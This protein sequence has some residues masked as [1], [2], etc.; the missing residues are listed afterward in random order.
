MR[1][2]CTIYNIAICC[3]AYWMQ[4]EFY[5]SENFSKHECAIKSGPFEGFSNQSKVNELVT[6]SMSGCNCNNY[7]M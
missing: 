3:H 7:K 4:H 5:G 2:L 6:N 1:E